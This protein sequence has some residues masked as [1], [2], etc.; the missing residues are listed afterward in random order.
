MASA[1]LPPAI[2][3]QTAFLCETLFTI[4]FIAPFYLSSTLR[5]SALNSRNAPSV[6]RA[7]TRAVGLVCIVCTLI[8]V[9]I[10]VICG[11]ATPNEVLRLLGLWPAQ[12][13]DVAKVIGLVF[14][15]FSCS[16]YELIIVDG[17][18]RNWSPAAF[19][20]G[21]W[22][23]WIGYRNLL[24]APIG[25]EVVF[26]S[27]TIP[28]FFVAK[29]SPTTIIFL[30][31]LVFGGAHLHHLVEFV[32]SRTPAGSRYPP[33]AVWVN[34]IAMSLF[35][36]TYTSLFGFFAAFVFLRSGNLWAVI[37]AHSFCNKMG[38]PR[39]WGKVGQ[40]DAFDVAPADANPL[41]NGTKRKGSDDGPASPV[42]AG[43]SLVPDERPSSRNLGISW[44]VI[45]YLLIPI[46]MFGFSKL[47]WPL[48]ASRNA[49]VN[50]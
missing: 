48:T 36:F 43:N 41:V 11:H 23:S 3:Q 14:A 26:R 20:E 31:P 37:A 45:Y 15:L 39:L 2:S 22:D 10:L 46:G 9:Y 38:V 13:I 18:W 42:L 19:K 29:A 35:Q 21:I 7:R 33:P 24:I 17:D 12:L 25:E 27:L 4:L 50:L 6:I 1:P 40:F 47:L 34:G 49:L 28:L 32:Q 5:Q 16:L 44:T 8:T 30:T